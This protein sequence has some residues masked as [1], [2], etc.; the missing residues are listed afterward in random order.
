MIDHEVLKC[1]NV[2]TFQ[3]LMGLR[4]AGIISL[5]NEIT[6]TMKQMVLH[7]NVNTFSQRVNQKTLV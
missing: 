2:I 3:D 5:S 7:V 1:L 6:I 4:V